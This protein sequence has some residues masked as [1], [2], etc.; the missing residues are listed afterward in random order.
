MSARGEYRP[1]V[2]P[3]RNPQGL[4]E[5]AHTLKD[6]LSQISDPYELAAHLEVLGYNR[7]RVERLFGLPSTFALAQALFALAQRDFQP[8]PKPPRPRGTLGPRHLAVA[9]TLGGTLVTFWNSGSLGW[10]TALFLL[11]WS[12]LAAR[13]S[14]RAAVELEP[15]EAKG[16]LGLLAWVGVLGVSVTAPLDLGFAATWGTGMAWVAVGV[17]TLKGLED[18]AAWVAS[19]FL[20]LAILLRVSGMSPFWVGSFPLVLLLQ[21]AS[22]LRRDSFAFLGKVLVGE[23]VYGAYGLGQGFVLWRLVDLAG[24]RAL[25]GLG[26]YLLAS[27]LVEMRLSAFVTTLAKILWQTASPGALLLALQRSLW[28]YAL[29]ASVPTLLV[30]LSLPWSGDYHAPLL[31]FGFLSFLSA[32]ALALNALGAIHVS[33]L[34]LLAGAILLHLTA[35]PLILGAVALG[36]LLYLLEHLRHPERYGLYLL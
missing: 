29:T 19:G 27:I 31:G 3:P 33:A 34:A 12:Q 22:P 26:I 10:L 7:Y 5:L 17:L 35:N 20:L 6:L 16:V 25:V 1:S 11:A 18:K 2:P 14:F 23:W 28:S 15:P 13:V 24:D 32:M 36:L 8:R 30:L 4:S 9:L 21:Q